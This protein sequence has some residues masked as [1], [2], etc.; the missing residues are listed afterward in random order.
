MPFAE[1]LQAI[2]RD[3]EVDTIGRL[4]YARRESAE[5]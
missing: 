3:L 5:R 4:A 1:E 2:L